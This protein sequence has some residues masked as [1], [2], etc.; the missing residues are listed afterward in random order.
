MNHQ[1]VTQ[2]LKN[3][4]EG[5]SNAKDKLYESVYFELKKTAK[6][7]RKRY[8]DAHTMNTTALVHEAYMKMV[9]EN[10]EWQNRLHFYYI[11][12]KVMRQILYNYAEKKMAAKR[13]SNK[14]VADVEEYKEVI[15]LDE[16]SFLE[17]YCLENVLKQLEEEDKIYGDIVECRFYSGMTIEETAQALNISQATVK[18]KW[19]FAKAWL[20][21]E[22]K[23]SSDL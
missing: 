5:D 4:N 11:A 2:L 3:L 12:G 22:M 1:E 18:R 21:K 16:K 19:N 14:A 17:I 13:G 20:L 15:P 23:D 7:V 8:S 10:I 6:S 9:P